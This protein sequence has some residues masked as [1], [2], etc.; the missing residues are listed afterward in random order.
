MTNFQNILPAHVAM[1]M[2]AGTPGSAVAILMTAAA[3]DKNGRPGAAQPQYSLDCTDTVWRATSLAVRHGL[4]MEWLAAE[5][6]E[7]GGL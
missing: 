2:A 6:L 1:A 3:V 7:V 4:L 5:I